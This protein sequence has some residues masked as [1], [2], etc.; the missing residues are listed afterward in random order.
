MR[1]AVLIVAVAGVWIS[2]A[3]SVIGF[4]LP[5]ATLDVKAAHLPGQLTQALPGADLQA[6]AGKLTS[7]I[8]RVTIQFK[9]GT[10]TIAGELLPDLSTIP[11]SV[12]GLEI[13]QLVN[14][15]DAKVAM[16]FAEMFTGQRDLGAKSYAVYLVPALALVC[17]AL[18]TL[19]SG[20]RVGRTLRVSALLERLLS[21]RL[22][23]AECAGTRPSATPPGGGVPASVGRTLRVS[24][25]PSATP[26]GGGV[27]ASVGRTLRVSAL[28]S[29]TPPGGGVP[30][31]VVC[32]GIGGACLAIAGLGFWKLLTT[33]S[34]TLFVAITLG[35]GLWLSLWAYVGLGIC[36]I[37]FA[38]TGD[39]RRG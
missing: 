8:G 16:A 35:P 38:L 2:V 34:D 1:R 39:K 32:G 29:A 9:R 19:A 20:L 13:P 31:S 3:A 11:T 33:K 6:L 28:P 17:G 22:R 4:V 15:Q 14:R 21:E 10:E 30:A 25:L 18:V 5:W 12:S 27:P 23:N 26:P 37:L 24:A 36:A 7:K